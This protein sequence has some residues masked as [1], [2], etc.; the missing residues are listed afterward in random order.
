MRYISV[1]LLVL[2]L[3]MAA[4]IPFIT[5]NTTA[6]YPVGIYYNQSQA[7]QK[8]DLVVFCP[9]DNAGFETAKERGYVAAGFC[10]RGY[11]LLIKKI[12]AAKNDLVEFTPEGVFVNEALIENSVPKLTDRRGRPMPQM[13]GK[14]ILDEKQVLL[15]SDYNPWSFDARYFGLLD[16][17][18]IKTTIKPLLTW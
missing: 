9:P 2:F 11:G 15:L 10:P 5:I 16:R 17:D 6:S 14:Y 18:R 7:P 3:L 8:G 1:V 13:T 12:L 4:A